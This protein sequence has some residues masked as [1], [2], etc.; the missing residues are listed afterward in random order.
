MK[1]C[2]CIYVENNFLRQSTL[3]TALFCAWKKCYS[4]IRILWVDKEGGVQHPWFWFDR[5][6]MYNSTIV[7]TSNWFILFYVEYIRFHFLE[8]R[9]GFNLSFWSAVVKI[10]VT[11]LFFCNLMLCIVRTPPFYLRGMMRS[12]KINRS[13]GCE[14]F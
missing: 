9:T 6:S 5:I 1:T 10:C 8:L 7:A 11:D 12:P 3:K 4:Q 2:I 14:V 13:R